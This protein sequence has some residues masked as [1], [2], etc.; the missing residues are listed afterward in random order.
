MSLLLLFGGKGRLDEGFCG[1]VAVLVSLEDLDDGVGEEDG[2]VVLEFLRAQLIDSFHKAVLFQQRLR[3]LMSFNQ[4]L[5][6]VE[7][8]QVSVQV[9]SRLYRRLHEQLLVRHVFKQLCHIRLV[10][11]LILNKCFM[12]VNSF[13]DLRDPLQIKLSCELVTLRL[14]F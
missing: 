4:T 9:L 12:R 8:N 13:K 1:G 6:Q 3:F 10:T 14:L 7:Q 11:N 5:D 2:L